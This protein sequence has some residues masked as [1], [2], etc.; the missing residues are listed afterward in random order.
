MQAIG[1][2][3]HID[4][5]VS[6]PCKQSNKIRFNRVFTAKFWLAFMATKFTPLTAKNVRKSMSF[7][8]QRPKTEGNVVSHRVQLQ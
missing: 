4:D 6:T 1:A 2:Y 7:S 8:S 5:A 3:S